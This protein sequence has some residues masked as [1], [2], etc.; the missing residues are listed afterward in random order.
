MKE[1]TYLLAER[2][3]E[4]A[5]A[6]ANFANTLTE[7]EWQLPIPHDGRTVGVVVHHVA[8]MYPIDRDRAEGRAWGA[9]RGS[10]VGHRQG[11]QR[12]PRERVR[13]C[14]EGRSDRPVAPQQSRRGVGDSRAQR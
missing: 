3:E 12:A 4:G 6:L 1:R 10:D 2:L 5:R 8:S 9:D 7:E 11:H 13:G 14:D